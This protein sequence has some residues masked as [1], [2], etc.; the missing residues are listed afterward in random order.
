MSRHRAL[1]LVLALLCALTGLTGV[2]ATGSASASAAP[3]AAGSRAG[4]APMQLGDRGWRVRVLQSRLHQLGLHSE[5]V[6][7]TFD[8]ETRDGVATVQR[9]RGWTADGVVDERTWLKIVSL[10]TQPTTEALH[11][12][13]APGK[14]LLQ[15]GDAGMW[16][17]QVQAR[18]KQVRWYDARVTGRYTQ[19]TVKAVEGFQAKRRIPVTGAVDRRTL[20]RLKAMTRE[21][22]KA[23]LFNIVPSGPAL[24]P[25]CLTGRL[26]Y[27]QGQYVSAAVRVD[28]CMSST[29]PITMA[30]EWRSTIS[31]TSQSTAASASTSSGTP[32]ARVIHSAP[33]KRS[34]PF[35]PPLPVNRS[36][37][38]S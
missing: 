20:T 35:R 23:E 10:T 3:S 2:A 27:W 34:A 28:T 18:L 31:S 37:I 4:F 36:A 11:N 30:W 38:S 21:P 17:R 25:R 33:A 12:V 8:R 9:R 19:A 22:T 29:R 24:D 15:R 13:Y 5:V 26:A 16:V 1:A 14:P 32:D 6:T 7:N